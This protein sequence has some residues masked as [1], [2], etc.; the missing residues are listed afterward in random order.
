[1]YCKQHTSWIIFI[2]S[3]HYKAGSD[4]DIIDG[5]RL[6]FTPGGTREL[7]WPFVVVDDDSL[8]GDEIAEVTLTSSVQRREPTTLTITIQ[9][10]DRKFS[11]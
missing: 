6:T 4:F 1:M 7:C 8:E 3:F 10:N 5:E 2:L 11:D 9:D